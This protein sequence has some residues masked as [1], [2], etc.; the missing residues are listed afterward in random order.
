MLVSAN[1]Q[2]ISC[3][4]YALV[5]F[6]GSHLLCTQGSHSFFQVICFARSGKAMELAKNPDKVA[7]ILQG[8][9]PCMVFEVLGTLTQSIGNAQA[10]INTPLASAVQGKC[11]KLSW[12]LYSDPSR[13]NL[14][15]GTFR[16]LFYISLRCSLVTAAGDILSNCGCNLQLGY[17]R[18]LAPGVQRTRAFRRKRE[19][20]GLK[21]RTLVGLTSN[22][23]PLPPAGG[24]G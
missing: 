12:E 14:V 22:Q 15:L 21:K 17:F 13:L 8:T 11:Y 4:Y 24:L 6:I 7:K 5:H 16:V 9:L 23:H 10:P 18:P 2:A 1:P 3:T 20:P 19:Y